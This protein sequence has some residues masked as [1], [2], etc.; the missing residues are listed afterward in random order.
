[1]ALLMHRVLGLIPRLLHWGGLGWGQEIPILSHFPGAAFATAA[2]GGGPDNAHGWITTGSEC[3]KPVAI[4]HK[5]T[6]SCVN[7]PS[8][9][10]I[11]SLGCSLVFHLE[12]VCLLH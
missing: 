8:M 3:R 12:S 10:A 5:H 9:A 4:A 7:L 11:L 1:M 2:G 6:L